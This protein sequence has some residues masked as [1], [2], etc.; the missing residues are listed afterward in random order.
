[1][2][3]LVLKDWSNAKNSFYPSLLLGLPLILL[4]SFLDNRTNSNLLHQNQFYWLIYFYSSISVFY[5]SFGFEHRFHNFH[6]YRS[7]D[8]APWKVFASQCLAH[9]GICILIGL[10]YLIFIPIFW[11]TENWPIFELLALTAA[12]AACQTPLGCL[13][14]LLL[15]FEREFL[16]ALFFLPIMTPLLLAAS[17]LSEDFYPSWVYILSAFFLAGSFVSA[18]V[19]Q[20]FFD[21]LTQSQ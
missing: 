3:A 16:F 1:M 2:L 15:Q 6:I 13:L 10:A 4:L 8:I 7:L 14:G 17:Q 18:L 12:I 9:F 21:E 5:R 19:F 20:F 11:P